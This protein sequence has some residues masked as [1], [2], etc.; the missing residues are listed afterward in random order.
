MELALPVLLKLFPNMLPSTFQ[1]KLKHEAGSARA[2]NAVQRTAQPLTRLLARC[3]GLQ[4]ALK[5]QLTAKLELAKFLQDT[6]EEM[7]KMLSS[8]RTGDVQA[9]FPSSSP[10]DSFALLARGFAVLTA[11]V[12]ATPG[13]S[14]RTVRL[15]EARA[16]RGACVQR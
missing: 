2:H 10:A 15:H 5:A 12:R 6:T 13:D 4:E 8:K 11:T 7:A 16:Q 3:G 14:R 1:D 9:R